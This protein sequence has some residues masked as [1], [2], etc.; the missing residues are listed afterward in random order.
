M[1]PLQSGVHFEGSNGL[2]GRLVGILVKHKDFRLLRNGSRRL[3]RSRGLTLACGLF[4]Q[5]SAA[6]TTRGVCLLEL[7]RQ[8]A[9]G[10]RLVVFACH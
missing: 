3:P 7:G 9:A 8:R 1:K 4:S 10:E 5:Y 2:G 6:L